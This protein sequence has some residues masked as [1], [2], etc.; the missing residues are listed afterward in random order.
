MKKLLLILALAV[1]GLPAAACAA[2]SPK[3]VQ[4]DLFW[5]ALS[6]DAW[7]NFFV[8]D[9]VQLRLPAGSVAVN[10]HVVVQKDRAGQW[11]SRKG[12]AELLE[13]GR[14]AAVQAHYSDK[15]RLYLVARSLDTSFHGWRGA[16]RFAGIDP[17]ALDKQAR[18]ERER[19]FEQN[20][21]DAD[22][23]VA[24][25]DILINGV[26]YSGKSEPAALL[27]K[28]NE[29]LP[30]ASRVAIPEA[31]QPDFK[32]WVVVSDGPF[33][34]EPTRIT[35]AIGRVFGNDDA[36]AKK[37]VYGS[38]EF[39]KNFKDVKIPVLPTFLF[40][41]DA[42]T[43]ETMAA[44]T[45]ADVMHSGDYI[46]FPE[47]SEG[48]YYPDRKRQANVLELFVMAQCPFGVM[49]ENALYDAIAAKTIPSN[50]KIKVHYIVEADR[51]DGVLEFGS[52]H[53]E[54]EW[55]EDARQMYIQDRHPGKFWA[56]LKA[57]NEDY[58][59]SEWEGAAKKAGLDPAEIT[60]GF[61]KG[62]ELLADDSKVAREY[63]ISASPTFVWE[64]RN[65]VPGLGA[66]SRIKGFEN[67]KTGGKPSGSCN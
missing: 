4:V 10:H 37:V 43:A 54:P 29:L 19:L 3:P 12:E 30:S 34:T 65:V 13:N 17:E 67:V 6:P 15:M 33:G 62:K 31:K 42:E 11:Q 21:K 8:V 24:K 32:M 38:S 39:K 57:R 51:K 53:G 59:S 40:K 23:K 22:G 58:R 18:A 63:K 50:V 16:A 47:T 7:R 25:P 26:S 5:E 55:M 36:T 64:G 49:A 35:K 41:Y 61:E 48:A 14:M 27:A 9:A 52:L 56:Y 2:S 60:K 1:C 28:I 20:L 46:V 45:G 66:L 44:V